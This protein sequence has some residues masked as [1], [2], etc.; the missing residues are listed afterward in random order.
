MMR[1]EG[2]RR[3]RMRRMLRIKKEGNILSVN[4]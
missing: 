1:E 3:K 4:P 2:G